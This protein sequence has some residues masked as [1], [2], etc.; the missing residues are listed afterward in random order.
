MN[1]YMQVYNSFQDLREEMVLKETKNQTQK[2]ESEHARTFKDDY[3]DLHVR[4]DSAQH[5]IDF[6][7]GYKIGEAKMTLKW[8]EDDGLR[9]SS[10]LDD[11]E[12]LEADGEHGFN[13]VVVEREFEQRSHNIDLGIASV[14]LET[15][16]EYRQGDHEKG[17]SQG[18]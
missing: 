6:R 10:S 9:I 17:R 2:G 7:L 1:Y 18:V 4:M 15:L 5:V 12:V 3:F 14:V 16:R 11:D 8:A 13:V